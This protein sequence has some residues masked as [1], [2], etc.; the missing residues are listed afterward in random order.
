MAIIIRLLR[1]RAKRRSKVAPTLRSLM[2][3]P[4]RSTLVDSLNRARTPRF[5]ISAR[6]FKSMGSPEIGVKSTL[7][8]PE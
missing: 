4:S 6:R 7:K 3:K 2:E 1:M 5:P 8:S